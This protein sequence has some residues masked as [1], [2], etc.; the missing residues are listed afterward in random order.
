MPPSRPLS[1]PTNIPQT[2]QEGQHCQIWIIFQTPPVCQRDPPKL[3]RSR[4]IAADPTASKEEKQKMMEML[5]RF[6]AG[7][8]G[9]SFEGAIVMDS[10]SSTKRGFRRGQTLLADHV[11]DDGSSA[12]FGAKV[13]VLYPGLLRRGNRLSVV[14]AGRA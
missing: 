9:W 11:G 13:G 2:Y 1:Q 10:S 14:G 7:Q 4:A 5:Q 12:Y 3:S 8:L 6:E